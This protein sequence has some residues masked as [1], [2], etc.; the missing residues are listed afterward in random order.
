MKSCYF[1]QETVKDKDGGYIPC[2]AVENERGYYK[3]DWNWG[4]N[5]ELARQ[6]ADDKNNAMGISPR[7]AYLIVLSSMYPKGV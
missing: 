3:T 5:L 1:I 4:D 7:E 6:C 2:I